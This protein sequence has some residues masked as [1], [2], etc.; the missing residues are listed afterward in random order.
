M[1]D[2]TASLRNNYLFSHLSDQ[3]LSEVEASMKSRQL[4]AGEILFN[5]GDPGDELYIVADG[6]IAIYAPDTQ[7]PGKEKPIRIFEKDEAL[8]EMAVIERKPRS[9]SARAVEPSRVLAFG[10][11]AFR[12]LIQEEPEMAFAVM[13]DLSDRIRYTTNF[14]NEVR[15]WVG[16]VTNGEYSENADFADEVRGWM[17]NI[18]QGDYESAEKAAAA[19]RDETLSTLAAEFAHMAAEVKHREDALRQEIV[20]LQIQID[21]EKRKLDLSRVKSAMNLDAIREQA[22]RLRSERDDG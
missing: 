21:E 19:Y 9:L 7:S 16:R 5:M 1:S 3:R 15:T 14:L 8:G 11:D 6:K 18:A 20:E 10:V 13:K 22:A 17:S 4:Q 12:S 2:S